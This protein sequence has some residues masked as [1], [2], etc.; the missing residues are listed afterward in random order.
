MDEQGTYTAELILASSRA[1]AAGAVLRQFDG[2]PPAEGESFT[3]WTSEAE[4]R[5][6]YLAN[7][8]AAGRPALFQDH[9]DW[10]RRAYTGRGVPLAMLERH[11]KSLRD[12]LVESLPAAFSQSASR[13]L[14]E[15]A[16]QLARE[17]PAAHDGLEGPDA[18]ASGE[19]LRNVLE[20]RREDAVRVVLD[21]IDAGDDVWQTYR[22]IVGRAQ[23]EVGRMWQMGELHVAE[24][25]YASR[26]AEHVLAVLTSRAPKQPSTGRRV[27]IATVQGD[28]HDIGAR[29]VADRLQ[30]EGFEA[31]FLGA[32][33]PAEDM[34]R[35]VRDFR[36]D[37]LAI[38][39]NLGLHVMSLART[40]ET[41]R[42]GLGD[43]GVPI[44]VGGRL[45]AVVEDL[46]QVVG[47]DACASSSDGAVAAVERV[48]LSSRDA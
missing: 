8:L 22:G 7:A 26:V 45:F 9:V 2:P 46:W 13:V 48:L 43:A 18:I 30:A 40:I 15:S 31:I 35:A 20:G 16:A 10:L 32:D 38:S 28:S 44:L 3:D 17:L 29:F 21:R 24:E 39:M 36:A 33:T 42:A 19:Y 47:A 6:Q 1:F 12:E 5:L 14:E 37:L 25:H 4:V 11:L 41:V 27:L 23:F 34:T